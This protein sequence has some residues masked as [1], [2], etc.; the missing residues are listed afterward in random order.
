MFP[1][2]HHSPAIFFQAG[3][4]GSVPTPVSLDLPAP[5]FNVGTGDA[6][7]S[8]TPMPKTSIDEDSETLCRKDKIRSSGQVTHV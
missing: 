8:W 1:D 7:A 6:L 2:S 3:A 4:H 5:V